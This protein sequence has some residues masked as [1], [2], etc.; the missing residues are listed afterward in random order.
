MKRLLQAVMVITILAGTAFAQSD[1]TLPERYEPKVMIEAPI[2]VV[3]FEIINE[4]DT[5]EMTSA[6]QPGVFGRR[7]DVN[8]ESALPK[9]MDV[10]S[11]GNIYIN[12]PA[13][14]RIQVFSKEGKY[15]N[16]IDIHDAYSIAT[17]KY[18]EPD[19]VNYKSH[20]ALAPDGSIYVHDEVKN[21][22]EH[23]DMKG[24]VLG[25]ESLVRKEGKET[26]M[27]F[28]EY[29]NKNGN[30]FITN[31]IYSK[32][33]IK[34]IK[35][36]RMNNKNMMVEINNQKYNIVTEQDMAGFNLVGIDKNNK[37]Y[38]SIL[39]ENKNWPQY[40]R[41]YNIYGK[42]ITSFMLSDEEGRYLVPK[43]IIIDEDGRYYEL[44]IDNDK[45]IVIRWERIAK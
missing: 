41:K 17:D 39:E 22:V 5:S 29:F 31:S 16:S 32:V 19:I 21:E 35:L 2:K 24:N 44:K 25:K 12:D 43:K 34:S 3:P 9:D 15:I 30:Y 23:I 18:G 13:N 26:V 42:L 38:F 11:A 10:D 33:P 8:I 6:K 4:Y 1:T 45:V 7:G 40:I 28:K 36:K 14:N 37:H 27:E 20:F